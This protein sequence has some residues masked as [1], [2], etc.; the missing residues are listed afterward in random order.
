M[1]MKEAHYLNM[2]VEVEED[3]ENHKQSLKLLNKALPHLQG[4][5]PQTI[6]WYFPILDRL[7]ML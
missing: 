5:V 3:A 7:N 2:Y 1:V 6:I 4:V